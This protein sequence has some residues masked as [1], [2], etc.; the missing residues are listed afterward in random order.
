MPAGVGADPVIPW[1]IEMAGA[2]HKEIVPVDGL[3][4]SWELDG[5]DGK[6]RLTSVQS[7]FDPTNPPY[8]GWAG[9]LAGVAELR[10][11]HELPRWR[12][13]WRQIEVTGLPAGMF[14][15]D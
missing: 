11:Y 7:G 15:S 14:A 4:S 1:I 3:I 8:P 6:T 10:R 12:S 5:S 9:W 2:G 13:I